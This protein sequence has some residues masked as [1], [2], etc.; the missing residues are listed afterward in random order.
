MLMT[1]EVNEL[2]IMVFDRREHI[3][4]YIYIYIYIH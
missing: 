4:I 3:Y 1:D 2:I